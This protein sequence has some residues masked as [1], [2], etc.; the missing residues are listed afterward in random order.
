ML[1][2]SAKNI[3]VGQAIQGQQVFNISKNKFI[4]TIVS[5]LA[6]LKFGFAKYC[7]FMGFH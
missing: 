1:Q 2:F 3:E 7:I 5:N 6:D 4:F